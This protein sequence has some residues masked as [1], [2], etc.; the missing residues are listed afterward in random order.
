M[1]Y[2]PTMPWSLLDHRRFNS[3]LMQ[4][5]VSSDMTQFGFAWLFEM[6]FAGGFL[7][8]KFFQLQIQLFARDPQPLRVVIALAQ[9]RHIT[10]NW[11]NCFSYPAASCQPEAR[12]RRARAMRTVRNG[13]GDRPVERHAGEQAERRRTEG[14]ETGAQETLALL[15]HLH[16]Q[17][18][19]PVFPNGQPPPRKKFRGGQWPEAGSGFAQNA[20]N[21]GRA[22]IGGRGDNREPLQLQRRWR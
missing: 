13:R 20:V 6:G 2:Y 18:F 7:L 21:P 14:Q 3:A 17:E 11:R 1:G 10:A 9:R 15:L 12:S 22:G 8:L 16:R 19:E 5:R 4:S